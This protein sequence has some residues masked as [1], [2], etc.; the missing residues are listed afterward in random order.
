MNDAAP[1]LGSLLPASVGARCTRKTPL[2]VYSTSPRA[3]LPLPIPRKI[4][5]SAAAA[6]WNKYFQGAVQRYRAHIHPDDGHHTDPVWMSRRKGRRRI[7]KITNNLPGAPIVVLVPKEC[8]CRV[9]VCLSWSVYYP[10][11][12]VFNKN[13]SCRM[14]NTKIYNAAGVDGC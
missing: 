13:L 4:W 8:P 14:V 7:L 3:F 1:Q 2:S 12:L 11:S 9:E 6:L 5:P 10:K